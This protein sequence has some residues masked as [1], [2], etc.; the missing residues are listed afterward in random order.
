MAPK[1]I[2]I[3]GLPSCLVTV[4]KATDVLDETQDADKKLLLA[5]KMNDTAMCL[6][7]VSLTD[8]VSQMALYNGITIE[9]PDGDAAKVWNTMFKLFHAKNINKMNELKNEF[10]Q[11]TLL[12]VET[13]P[14]EWIAELYFIRR[15]LEDDY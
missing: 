6:F 2:F 4:P 13:N 9:L 15:R 5:R 7:N 1:R 10:V 12:S 3:S 14:D 8:T 11:S